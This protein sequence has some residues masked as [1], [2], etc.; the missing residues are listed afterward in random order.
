MQNKASRSRNITVKRQTI[1]HK[2]LDTDGCTSALKRFSFRFHL[3]DGS[4]GA[5]V[6][7]IGKVFHTFAAAMGKAWSPI[8]LCFERGTI[9]VTVEADR[10]RRPE[11]VSAF[12]K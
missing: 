7:S 6:T 9:R 5:D 12:S 8:V 1:T 2:L 11:F 3:K 10:S 4:D